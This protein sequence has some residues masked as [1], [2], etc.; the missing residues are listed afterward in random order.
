M[1]TPAM[2]RPRKMTRTEVEEAAVDRRKGM[3]WNALSV[4]YNCAINTLRD[5]LSRYSDEFNPST[6][7]QKAEI[8]RRLE[9]IEAKLDKI[10]KALRK[11]FN[12]HI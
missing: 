4:K 2:G 1:N 10:E 5:S 7:A 11:R 12:I 8:A 6:P 3:T 9:G